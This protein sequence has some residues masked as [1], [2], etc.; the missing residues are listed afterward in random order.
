MNAVDLFDQQLNCHWNNHKHKK[1]VQCW[2]YLLVKMVFTNVSIYY[3]NHFGTSETVTELLKLLLL[4]YMPDECKEKPKQ[5]HFPSRAEK[6]GRSAL[7][8]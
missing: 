8:A 6:I 4:F 5:K 1:W 3:N 2:F 7:I